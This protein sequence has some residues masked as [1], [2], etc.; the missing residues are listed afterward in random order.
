MDSVTDKDFRGVESLRIL[1]A[2]ANHGEKNRRFCEH[3]LNVY[4][5]FCATVDLVVL[6]DAP[7]D[8]GADVEVRVGAP[9]ADPWSL[10]FGHRPLFAERAEDYDLFI[11]SEDDTEITEAHVGAFLDAASHLP[12]DMIPG[13][14]RHEYGPDGQKYCEPIHGPYYWDPAS[15]F[16]A[17][18]HVYASYT[19][20]HAAS[21]ILTRAQLRR[22]IAS[23]GFLVPP[24]KGRYDMLCAAATDPYIHCGMTKVIRISDLDAFSLHHLPNKNVGR[25]GMKWEENLAQIDRLKLLAASG[26]KAG[27]LFRTEVDVETVEFDKNHEERPNDGVVAR[28]AAAPGSVLSVGCEGGATEGALVA[29]GCDVASI[30]LDIVIA[31]ATVEFGV[32]ELPMDIADPVLTAR[33]FD[34]V[35]FN[36]V[37]SHTPDPAV[38]IRRF[39]R[40]IREG[41][42]LVVANDN[43]ESVAMRKKLRRLVGARAAIFPPRRRFADAGYHFAAASDLRRWITA[44]GFHSSETHWRPADGWPTSISAATRGL[45]DRWL[46]DRVVIVAERAH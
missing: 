42:R 2:I 9:I 3:L 32:E 37:L 13:F 12:E 5:G 44:A 45:A 24:H 18:G 43:V 23:G 28:L 8:L 19:N 34:Y 25:I 11:Y 29:A 10:P 40:F 26:R 7:K 36:N 38:F 17:G 46:A 35:L 16:E 21:Y 4:R 1:V 31:A 20:A 30:P 15:A 33:E 39:L 6:S 27:R 22:C 14:L 41:G